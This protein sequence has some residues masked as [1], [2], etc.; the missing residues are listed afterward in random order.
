MSAM[1]EACVAKLAKLRERVQ[2]RRPLLTRA[3]Q[4]QGEEGKEAKLVSKDVSSPKET[5]DGTMSEATV[6]LLMDRFVPW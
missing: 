2:A 3:K 6:C 1:V 4:G 5:P